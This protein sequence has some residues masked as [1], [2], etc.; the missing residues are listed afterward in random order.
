LKTLS[1]YSSKV[2][3]VQFLILV[4]PTLIIVGYGLFRLN[5]FYSILEN[6]YLSQ[7]FY[8]AIG[9][10]CSIITYRFN[11]K[12]ISTYLLLLLI[13]FIVYDIIERLNFGE[14]DVFY[15]SV[16]FYIFSVLFCFGWLIG[17]ALTRNKILVILWATFLVFTEV[18]TLSKTNNFE[19]NTIV[20][21][22]IPVILYFVFIL[23]SFELIK[24]YKSNPKQLYSKSI[25]QLSLFGVL[26]LLFLFFTTQLFK[27]EFKAIE[28]EWG[29][30]KSKDNKNNNGQGESM[31]EN[32]KDGGIKNKDQSKLAG[33]LNKDKQLVFVAKLNN[34]FVNTNIPNPL[35]FTA[36]YYTKFDTAT[37]TFE[38]DDKMPFNDL[39]LPNPSEI[40]LYFKKTDSSIIKK[41][42]GTLNREIVSAEVYKVAMSPE[43][44]VAPSN[45]FYCQPISV[46]DEFKDK[47]KSAYLSKMWVSQ[48]NSA[49]FIYN[50]AGNKMLENFQE[51]RF[52][53]LRTISNIKGPNKSFDDYYTYM[54]KNAEYNR[55]KILA[56][57]ISK[58]FVAPIDKVIAIRNYFL[59][60]DQFNQPLYKYTD[61]PG[62]PGLPSANKL[63]Y[64]LFENRKG[65]CAYFAGATLFMLR[66]LNIPSRIAVGY[67]TEDRSSK[68]PGWYWFY[69]DQAHAWVQVYFQNYGWIDFDTTIPDVNTQQAS[70]P[71]GTPPPE[72]PATYLVIDGEIKKIDTL[73]KQLTV[74]TKKFLYHDTEFVSQNFIVTINDVSLA[75]IHN[76]TGKVSLNKLIEGERATLVSHAEGL[77]NIFISNDT[78]AEQIINKLKQPLPIDE[79]K[80]MKKIEKPDKNQNQN[81]E[82]NNKYNWFN[83]FKIVLIC[84]I[85]STILV[86]CMPM[87]L[88]LYFK[89]KIKLRRKSQI[90]IIQRTIHFYL[91]QLNSLPINEKS[92][93][94]IAQLIDNKF[95]TEMVSLNNLY[96]KCYYSKQPLTK[97]EEYYLQQFYNTNFKRINSKF[98]I[99]QKFLNFINIKQTINYFNLT[100]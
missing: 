19:I 5:N 64:F 12:F 63:N 77:K 40:P 2:L 80:L 49:Y 30:G 56:D 75:D 81:K 53:I 29:G 68:N 46:P 47:Y 14:F 92:P 25:Q 15:F 35:Y 1:K 74:N 50:P 3:I 11:F 23:F 91:Y 95:G 69:Q 52:E 32:G 70:Q 54:P 57:S 16:K 42:L 87:L 21:S 97:E 18:I 94:I 10:I 48:L 100:K 84:I 85:I 89:T 7:T 24:K 45:A 72:V 38:I 66:S 44:F 8:F 86:L 62:V 71:D 96:Q 13:N 33:N 41:S 61:N 83:F 6:N 26:I 9:L 27:N 34:Y 20:K 76:D 37:Q 67:L 60:K 90:A 28:K 22:I 58:D 82:L 88:F 39:F 43:S 51:D 65:Y 73:N 4:I 31:T 17:Y 93:S 99:K 78:T 59:G 36:N 98:S 55:I 79:V